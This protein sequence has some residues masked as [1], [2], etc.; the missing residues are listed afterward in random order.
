MVAWKALG[1]YTKI[2][3]R[4]EKHVSYDN[5]MSSFYFNRFSVPKKTTN[6]FTVPQNHTVRYCQRY[7][8]FDYFFLNMWRETYPDIS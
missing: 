7:L 5:I 4:N 1:F 3:S 2:Q 8:E 6:S